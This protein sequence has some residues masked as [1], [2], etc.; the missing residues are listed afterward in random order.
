MINNDKS[1]KEIERKKNFKIFF[2]LLLCSKTG[3]EVHLTTCTDN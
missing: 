1:I 3:R 2:I